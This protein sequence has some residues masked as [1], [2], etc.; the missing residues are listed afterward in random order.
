MLSRITKDVLNVF[1]TMEQPLKNQSH[2]RQQDEV[3]GMLIYGFWKQPYTDTDCV[4]PLH[5]WT[6]TC[7]EKRYLYR[8]DD[9]H[10]VEWTLRII[11][12]PE[13]ELWNDMLRKTMEYICCNGA[14]V[15]WCG[16]EGAYQEPHRLFVPETQDGIYAAY[17]SRYGMMMHALL[18]SLYCE[19]S[20]LELVKLRN[21]ILIP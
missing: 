1:W 4:F 8:Y 7:A 21:I 13:S 9:C 3:A 5:F 10:V 14:S 18:D 17:T 2:V 19:L 6:H 12:W 15:A 16:L 11:D 20:D